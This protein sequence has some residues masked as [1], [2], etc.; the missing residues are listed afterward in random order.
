[1]PP[2]ELVHK[3]RYDLQM[4]VNFATESGVVLPALSEAEMREVDRVAIEETGPNLFQ[5]MENAGRSLAL[6]AIEESVGSVT[7][8]MVVLSGTGGNGGGGITAARHL[9]NHGYNVSLAITD[10]SRLR[11]VPAEQLKAYLGTAGEE[12]SAVRL[13]ESNPSLVIDALIGYSLKG[14]PK[15]RSADMIRWANTQDAPILSL[16]LPSGVDA[17][18]GEAPGE[19]VNATKTLTLALPKRGLTNGAAGSLMLADLGIP[20]E[21]YKRVGVDVPAGFF[22]ADFRIRLIRQTTESEEGRA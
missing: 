2:A 7:D 20:E 21:T 9:A 17:T 16:D 19:H 8:Q 1:M 13:S 3:H 10:R 11:G 6:T 14:P 22:G 4:P 12:M 15:G 5:M 18:S